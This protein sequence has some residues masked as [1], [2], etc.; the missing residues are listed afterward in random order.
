MENTSDYTKIDIKDLVRAVKTQPLISAEALADA[1]GVY[2]KTIYN[3]VKAGKIP[4]H[5][6]GGI[7]RFD[8]DEVLA[9]TRNQLPKDQANYTKEGGQ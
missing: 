9:S 4:Y 7:L 8:L 6:V 2:R 1:L 3:H 5:Y